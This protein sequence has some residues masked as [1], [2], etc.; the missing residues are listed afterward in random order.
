MRTKWL[1]GEDWTFIFG[2]NAF[3]VVL[4]LINGTGFGIV[5]SVRQ[6]ISDVHQFSLF[7]ACFQC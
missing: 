3:I 2:L 1:G 7:P 5:F 6:I 4:M